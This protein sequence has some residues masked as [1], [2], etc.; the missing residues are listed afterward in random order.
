MDCF[1]EKSCLRDGELAA[2]GGTPPSIIADDCGLE[3]TTE[4]AAHLE[5]M[6]NQTVDER[7]LERRHRPDPTK[8]RAFLTNSALDISAQHARYP[9]NA[10]APNIAAYLVRGAVC[11]RHPRSSRQQP[12]VGLCDDDGGGAKRVAS[13]VAGSA[14]TWN[15]QKDTR[16]RPERAV[17]HLSLRVH[18]GPRL[19]SC[20][21]ATSAKHAPGCS[22]S[23]P[24]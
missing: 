15:W 6:I 11:K 10:A 9:R 12:D 14:S 1:Q 13:V 23:L 24:N 19:T 18:S 2:V 5:E 3:P 17:P 20:R 22:S 21:R 8:S 7:G 4:R 16:R